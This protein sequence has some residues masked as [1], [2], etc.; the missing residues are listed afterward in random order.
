MMGKKRRRTRGVWRNNT[1]T[2]ASWEVRDDGRK[3]TGPPGTPDGKAHREP[4]WKALRLR[5]VVRPLVG[6]AD[7]GGSDEEFL[8]IGERD[9][10]SVGPKRAVLGLEALDE[11]LGALGQGVLVPA[12]TQQRVRRAPFNHPALDLAGRRVLHVDVN[13]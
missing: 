2:S 9:V 1:L 7:T 4:G 5:L 11:D 6:S 13:P 10:T 8:A 3:V 12:A